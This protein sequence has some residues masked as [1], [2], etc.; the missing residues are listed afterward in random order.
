[1]RQ[2]RD[3]EVHHLEKPGRIHQQV[4]RLDVA[5][6][7][8]LLVRHLERAAELLPDRERGR[9][10]Q[11]ARLADQRRDGG[12]VHVLHRDVVD[13]VHLAEIVGPH[14]VAV[15]DPPRQ[16]ELLLEALQQRGVDARRAP[17]ASP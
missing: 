9:H 15:G 14:H 5:V 3:P 10:G 17:G 16:P 8:A 4:L 11:P 6:D 1:M 7:D 2:P 12:A 13:P